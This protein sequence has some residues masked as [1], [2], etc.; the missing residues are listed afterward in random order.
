MNNSAQDLYINIKNIDHVDSDDLT[1]IT[2]PRK[3]PSLPNLSFSYSSNDVD[4]RVNLTQL[5]YQAYTN[6]MI[7]PSD[8]AKLSIANQASK[9]T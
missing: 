6:E 9:L 2:R 7:K 1:G 4:E 5:A 3:D 8:L